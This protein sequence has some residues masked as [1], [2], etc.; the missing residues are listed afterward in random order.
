MDQARRDARW[1]QRRIIYNNDGDD[2]LYARDGAEHE[3]DVAEALTVR[4]SGELVD[5]FLDARSNPLIGSQV[6]SNWYASCMAG[7][8]FSHNTKLGGFYG[9]E[10]PLELVEKYG[11]DAL[12]VQLDFSRENGMEAVW[13]LR[14]NDAHDAYPMGSRRWTY[15]LAPFKAD[16][17]ECMLGEDGDW[18]KFAGVGRKSPWTKLDFSLP[19]VRDHIFGIIQ[20]VAQNY[21]VDAIGMEFFKYDPFFHE[22]REGEAVTSEHVEI[23]TDLLRRI[24]K[25]AD[26][27]GEKRGRPILLAAH[28]PPDLTYSRFIGLDLETWLAEDLIDQLIPGG[29]NESVFCD[30]HS[31]MIEFGHR[32]DVPVYPC[33]GWGFWTRW[34]YLDL[35]QGKHR[36]AGSYLETLYGGQPDRLGKPSYILQYN[37]WEGTLSAWRGAAMNL[38]NDGADGLY[39]FNP[40]LGEPAWWREIGET[41]TM[42]R[43]D[44]LFGVDRFPPETGNGDQVELNQGEKVGLSFLVGEDT[45]SAGISQLRLRAHMWDLTNDDEIVL[46]LN[47]EQLEGIE[48]NNAFTSPEEGQWLE[49]DLTSDQVV[50]GKNAVELSLKNRT[51]SQ[52]APLVLN[53]VQLK[54]RY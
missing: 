38:L 11:R 17:P 16:H 21:D 46:Q 51:E 6:D 47:G 36:T 3:H 12:Q 35:S 45:T 13:A 34:A 30:S 50:R 5:D 26:A 29:L 20:E 24:R 18:E 8:H 7:L 32:Y 54:V 15:G 25:M 10:L 19:I 40:A 37:G 44:K 27:E 52:Q 41:A 23:M 28:T 39:I 33:L 31:E 9:K 14:M 2:A 48:V 1:R 22:S 49:C 53:T 4:T 42:E 43:K